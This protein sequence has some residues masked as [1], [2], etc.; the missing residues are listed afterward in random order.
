[1]YEARGFEED[2]GLVMSNMVFGIV[3][4]RRPLG[5]KAAPR[6]NPKFTERIS[7]AGR[8][9][10]PFISNPR[11]RGPTVIAALADDTSS[12]SSLQNEGGDED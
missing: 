10:E 8:E 2:N 11:P 5:T 6:K 7:G 3:P 9:S 12:A 1:M 4:R